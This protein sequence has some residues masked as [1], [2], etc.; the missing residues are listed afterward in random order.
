MF[1]VYPL[2]LGLIIG[3]ISGG[4]LRQLAQKPLY[5]KW[6]AVSAILV[7]IV[8]FSSFLKSAPEM[9][10]V[11]LYYVSYVLLLVFALRN[12]KASGIAL[13]G[14]GIF[15]NGLV[16]F[17][18]GGYMPTLPENLK[19]TPITKYAEVISQVRAV[20]SSS[21]ITG[22]TLLPWLGDI[23]YVPSW[24][25]FS[26]VLSIGDILIGIGI[27]TYLV[28]NMRPSRKPNKPVYYIN[29]LRKP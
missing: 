22:Q 11:A 5:W 2:I 28:I 24:I 29:N 19:N 3:Y 23:F 13:I 4:N 8:I 16:T 27:F 10:R 7:Q 6:T 9:I 1:I 26:K 25:P 14:A 18:N 20:G 12:I 21:V 15:A 17:L